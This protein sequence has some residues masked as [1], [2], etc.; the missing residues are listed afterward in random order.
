MRLQGFKFPNVLCCSRSVS[1]ILDL[2]VFRFQ[3]KPHLVRGEPHI[4]LI[5][6]LF[7]SDPISGK[8]AIAAALAQPCPSATALSVRLCLCM[9]AT[10][11]EK[12]KTRM[13][14]Q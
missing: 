2:V 14:H 12:K 10:Q 11:A 4:R 9:R 1:V 13:V 6:T 7:L 5:F 8:N 3:C